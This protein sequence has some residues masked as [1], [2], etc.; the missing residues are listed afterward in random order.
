MVEYYNGT[1]L[2]S[3]KDKNGEQPEIYIC[4]SNRTAGKTT[5]FNRLLINRWLNRGEKFCLVYRFANELTDCANKFF[6][7]IQKLFFS[8]HDMQSIK[9]GNG[10]Y[11]DLTFDSVH[12]GYAIALNSADKIKKYSH[13]FSDTKRML[14]DE[15]Q[16][17]SGQYC[18]NEVEKLLSVHTSI[19]RGNGEMTRYVPLYMLGNDVSL[20]N[21][22]FV[23]L[24]ISNTINEKTNFMRGD[25]WVLEHSFNESAAEAQTKS[26]FNRAFS[27]N[28]YTKYAAQGIY[29]NDNKAFVQR[30]T[31]QNK[32]VCTIIYGGVS[33]GI[34]LYATVG[35]IYCDDKIDPNCQTRLS[36]DTSDH[37]VNYVMIYQYGDLI[38]RLRYLFNNGCF[39]FKNLQC[40]DAIFHIL[41]F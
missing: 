32:Y 40:K 28:A 27:Q 7:D 36:C 11:Y 22:Y 13:L 33:Y 2:L 39:R 26:A 34:R 35:I 9:A 12:C 24:G 25:G 16:L 14:F 4:T 8:G 17:E 41:S 23:A 3:L 6:K 18:T 21:P 29:L 10:A 37:G 38:N 19:A 5:Y 1:K 31:G 30:M 20:L 15:F